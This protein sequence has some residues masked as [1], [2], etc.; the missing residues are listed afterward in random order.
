MPVSWLT[1]LKSVPWTEVIANA[2]KLAD[3]AK[4]LWKRV[5]HKEGTEIRAPEADNPSSV[6]RHGDGDIVQ[7][8]ISALE[9]TTDELHHQMLGS[10]ELIKSLAEQNELLIARLES[11]RRTLRRVQAVAW[12]ALLLAA[13]ALWRAAG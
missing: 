12:L 13:A 11:Q 5:A 9:A 6:A 1:V 2:P 4:K 7:S 3:G 8:R 10:S